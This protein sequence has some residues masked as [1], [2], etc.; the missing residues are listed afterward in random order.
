[1]IYDGDANFLIAKAGGNLDAGDQISLT[2]LP[3]VSNGDQITIKGAQSNSPEQRR[4][5]LVKGP[6]GPKAQ[7]NEPKTES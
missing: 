6:N 1:M 2:P 7:K 4:P 5:P 3:F